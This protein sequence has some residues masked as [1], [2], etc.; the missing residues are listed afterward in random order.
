MPSSRSS[1]PAPGEQR[2]A[3]R[4]SP[5]SSRRTSR[6]AKE[7]GAACAVYH[8]GRKVVDFGVATGIAGSL[9]PWEKSTLVLVF[10]AT[11]GISAL[12]VALTH[13]RGLIDYEE[14]VAT[15]WPEFAHNGKENITVRQL[16][17]HQAGLCAIDEPLNPKY[18]PTWTRWPRSSLGRGQPG[19]QYKAWL[20][21]P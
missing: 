15:Y 14:K 3:S 20:P 9:A 12:T 18:W 10:S 1:K 11:K 17:G 8:R 16:L 7:V 19:S 4:R 2:P 6:S 21:P 13:S 5:L